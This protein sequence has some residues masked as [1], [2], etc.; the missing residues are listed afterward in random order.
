M[1]IFQLSR[2]YY[3][4]WHTHIWLLLT[5]K[6]ADN[7]MRLLNRQRQENPHRSFTVHGVEDP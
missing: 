2:W 7:T 6:G 5:I 4:E 3:A 1:D